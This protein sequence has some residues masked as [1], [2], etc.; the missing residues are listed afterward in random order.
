M[1]IIQLIMYNHIIDVPM[2]VYT[3]LC[4]CVWMCV[5][6]LSLR[7]DR[8]TEVKQ[9]QTGFVSHTGYEVHCKWIL[10]DLLK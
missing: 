1:S 3:R 9:K 8:K 4:L 7:Q 10:N 2:Y 5:C 6:L